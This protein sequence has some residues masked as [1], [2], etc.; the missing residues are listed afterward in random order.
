MKK[1]VMTVAL[2]LLLSLSVSAAQIAPQ[3]YG[4]LKENQK[5]VP[6]NLDIEVNCNGQVYKA[7]TDS[8]GAYSLNVG[9]GKCEFKLY[10]KGKTPTAVLYSSNNPLRYDFE[11]IALKGGL[12]Q[13]RRK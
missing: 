2:G 1:I 12:Y 11:I 7:K 10:Y 8:Y 6:A 4:T 3:I 9:K 13:L 5:A